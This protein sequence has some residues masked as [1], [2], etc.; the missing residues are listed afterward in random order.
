[1]KKLAI[2]FV[3]LPL[4]YV[5]AHA[6]A[7]DAA[8]GKALWSANPTLC[9]DCHGDEGQGAFGPDLAGRGLSPAQFIQAVRKPWGIMPRFVETQFSGKQLTDMAAYFATLPKVSE[10]GKWRFEA[11]ADT[12][13]GQQTLINEGCA[14]CHGPTF[15]GPR[16]SLGALQPD[17]DYFKNLVYNHTSAVLTHRQLL[18]NNNTNVLMGNYAPTRVTEAS[19]REIYDWVHDDIGFRAP[20]VARLGKGEASGNGV[21]YKLDV[22]NNGLVGKGVT[23]QGVTIRLIVP[24]GATVMNATGQGYQGAK[25]DERAKATVATWTVAT[26]PPKDA[27]SYTITLSKAGTADNNLKGDVKWA[28]PAPKVTKAEDAVNIAPAPL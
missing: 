15:N 20:I 7:G 10:P 27:Q 5:A 26:L 11:S 23:A 12:A 3:F 22:A 13:Q 4:S 8:A 14:Q 16:G 2:A 25:M 9:K 18:G 6:Q 28:S 1:M 19:L 17:F 21:T 24:Q